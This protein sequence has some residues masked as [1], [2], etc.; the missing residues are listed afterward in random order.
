[1]S[2]THTGMTNMNPA[3]VAAINTHR[4]TDGKFG[5]W[6]AGV[7]D[8][9][10]DAAAAG[11]H[12]R[13]LGI[14]EKQFDAALREQY[15]IREELAALALY[16]ISLSAMDQFPGAATIRLEPSM[17]QNTDGM[18]VTGIYDA[19]GAPIAEPYSH[20]QDDPAITAA[21]TDWSDRSGAMDLSMRLPS[22]DSGWFGHA[23]LFEDEDYGSMFQ[24]DLREVADGGA[25]V[26]PA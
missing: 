19:S 23:E 3:H 11:S 6:S 16:R 18:E 10:I 24:V 12:E 9:S 5:H 14:A 8:I 2:R 7:P 15:R 20:R 1:M 21:F 17:E 25:R 4:E 22:Q 26:I 13:E